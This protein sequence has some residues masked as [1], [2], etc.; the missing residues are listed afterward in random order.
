M[1]VTY[2]VDLILSYKVIILVVRTPTMYGRVYYLLTLGCAEIL[3]FKTSA[4]F[5]DI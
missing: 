4:F 5:Y 2:L 1:G 3:N